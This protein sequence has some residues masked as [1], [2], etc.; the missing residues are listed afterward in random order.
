MKKRIEFPIFKTKTPNVKKQFDLTSPK[1]RQEYFQAKAKAEI[2]KIRSFLNQNTFICY[3]LAKK[4][5]GKGTISKLFSQVIGDDYF[6]HLSVGD[7]VRKYNKILEENSEEKKEII[8]FLE[9]NYRGYISLNDAIDSLLG[10]SASNL[11]P[12]EFILT[13]VKR[14][15]DLQPKKSLFLDGFPRSL[16]QVSYSLYFRELINYRNDMDFF[17]LL[18]V[19]ENVIDERIKYRTVCPKCNTPRNLKLLPTSF[20]GFDKAQGSFYLMCD[21]PACKKQR[22]IRKEGDELGIETIKERLNNDGDLLQ[23]AL[24]LYGIDKILLR[25]TIPVG[26]KN[27]FDDYEITPEFYYKEKNG[28]IAT[29]TKPFIVKDDN[30]QE[31]YS[32]MPEAV[33][34][35]LIKQIADLI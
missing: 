7:I 3:L 28:T 5:A 33:T 2:E 27:L 16:D 25:N 12:T 15:I 30:N 14:E 10:R 34:L 11:L 32:L 35:S 17:V 19:A 18:D 29:K 20:V 8:S 13:L 22:M 1:E 9:K 23:K 6:A 21:N 26:K 24:S 31:S 4:G